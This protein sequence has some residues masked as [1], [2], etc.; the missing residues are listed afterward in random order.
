M[1]SSSHV[2]SI[3]DLAQLRVATLELA[4]DLHSLAYDLKIEIQR[5]T[6]WITT[7]APRYWR[8]ELQRA[9]REFREAQDALAA[10]QATVGG[11][12]KPAATEAK[13]RVA[14]LKQRVQ[15]C[16]AKLRDCKGAAFEVSRAAAGLFT[17]AAGI[18]GLCESDLS[19]ASARLERWILALHRYSET[20]PPA[21]PPSS[22]PTIDSLAQDPDRS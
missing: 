9:E 22:S 20:A 5:A 15:L 7:E 21:P 18:E 16:D 13:K 3:A 2:Q 11:R 4:S 17:C 10:M 12:D 8:G 19:L 1:T 6:D 14:I